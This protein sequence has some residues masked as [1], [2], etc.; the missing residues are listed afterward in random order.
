MRHV[1]AICMVIAVAG[2]ARAQTTYSW[3]VSTGGVWTTSHPERWQPQGTPVAGDHVVIGDVAGQSADYAVLIDSSVTTGNPL[4]GNLTV[5]NGDGNNGFIKRLEHTQNGRNLYVAG[6]VIH[7]DGEVLFAFRSTWR[8]A[9]GG[10]VTNFGLVTGGTQITSELN[11]GIISQ[12]SGQ[13]VNF[14]NRGRIM[15]DYLETG[16]A[17]S[18]NFTDIS[19]DNTGHSISINTNETLYLSR[20]QFRGGSITNNGSLLANWGNASYSSSRMMGSADNPVTLVNRAEGLIEMRPNLLDHYDL[21]NAGSVR[22]TDVGTDTSKRSGLLIQQGRRIESDGGLVEVQSTGVVSRVDGVLRL[23]NDAQFV[24]RD[25]GLIIGETG[26]LTGS[27]GTIRLEAGHFVVEAVDNLAF[28]ASSIQL[29]FSG[30][31]QEMVCVSADLGREPSAFVS[32]FAFGN[33]TCAGTGSLT[34]TG[35]DGDALYVGELVLDG[36]QTLDI[37]ARNVYVAD[38]VTASGVRHRNRQMFGN[39]ALDGLVSATT[40]RIFLYGQPTGVMIVVR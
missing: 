27:G 10:T 39:G 15:I 11:N 9:V 36:G 17:R 14:V 37:G 3:N 23:D 20:V 32:N 25:V 33:V 7:S 29:V 40:G 35:G 22:F 1:I 34:L 13:L 26:V 24:V 28:D 5:G 12:S 38:A 31:S 4:Y 16:L 18:L 2:A 19:F 21:Y 8:I 6:G 30:G